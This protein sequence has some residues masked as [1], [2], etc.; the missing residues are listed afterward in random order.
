MA[1]RRIEHTFDCSVDTFWTQVFFDPEYNDALF[2]KRLKFERWE[3][4]EK[5]ESE[6]GF[7]R[8][9]EAIPPVGDVPGPLKKLMKKG[10]GYRE[11]GVYTASASRYDVTVVS[12]SLPEKLVITGQ[13]T[14]EPRGEGQ[15]HRV[16]VAQ[17]SAK[18][19]GVG[20]LLENRVLDDLQRSYE[21]SAAFTKQWLQDRELVGK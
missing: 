1:E 12:A 18:I 3:T 8:V 21:K 17:V 5:R 10:A 7:T 11:T 16:Y 9:L 13:M 2:L 6:D 19:F 15:C 4:V 20:G 14:V